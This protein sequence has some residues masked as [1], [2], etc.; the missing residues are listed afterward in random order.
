MSE[1]AKK[2]FGTLENRF[3]GLFAVVC[4]VLILSK[5]VKKT[6][7]SLPETPSP[8]SQESVEPIEPIGDWLEWR[9]SDLRVAGARQTFEF[10]GVEYGFC[11]IPSGEFDMGSPESERGRLPDE[12]LRRVELTRGFW[13]LETPVTQKFYRDVV[14]DNPSFYQGDDLPV[15]QV[16]YVDALY[17]CEELT[18]RLPGGVKAS[19]PTE[20]QW[21]YACRAGT[22]TAYNWGDVWDREK[23][24]GSDSAFKTTPS[25]KYPPNAWGLYDMHGNVWEWTL[26]DNSSAS[27]SSEVAFHIARGGGYDFDAPNCRSASRAKWGDGKGKNT[28]FRVLIRND[29]VLIC[30]I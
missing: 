28:G 8:S 14:G 7:E 5:S 22:T 1:D 2:R 10:G 26:D 4:V 12:T 24:N 13:L 27:E 25:K 6:P 29:T 18:K 20:T 30:G 3:W 16:R 15:E 11:W 23:A 19:L 21:E 17:F 9:E